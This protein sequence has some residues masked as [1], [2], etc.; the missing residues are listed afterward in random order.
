VISLFKVRVTNSTSAGDCQVCFGSDF[1]EVSVRA[2]L[3]GQSVHKPQDKKSLRRTYLM[4]RI[5]VGMNL[6]AKITLGL[7]LLFALAQIVSAQ[8]PLPLSLDNNYMV[9][10]DY[11]V[12]GWTKT[13]GSIAINGMST[14]TIPI[15]DVAAYASG[16]PLQQVP[17]GADIVAAFLYWQAVENSGVHSGQNGFFG[18]NGHLYPIAGTVLGNPK[19]PVSWSSGGCNGGSGSKTMVT[20]R[21]EVSALLPVDVNGNILPNTTYNVS[22]PD[23]GKAGQ[24]PFTEGATLVIVYR[25]L[26]PN[27]PLNAVVIYDGA[28]APNNTSQI[29]TH[30]LIGFFQAGNDRAPLGQAPIA[31]KIT[32]IVGNGQSNK[33]EQVYL[34]N[35]DST[36]K[37]VHSTSL[38]SLYGA[39]PPFPGNYNGTWDNPTWFPNTYPT[40]PLADSAVMAGESSETTVVVPNGSNKGCVSWGAIVMSTTVQDTDLDGLL[41]VWKTNQGYYD[42]GA[43][44]GM[45]NQGT[46]TLSQSTC[47]PKASDPAWVDLSGA[48]PGK[49]DIFV[50]LDYMCTIVVK[51]AD[52]TTTCDLSGVSYK[53]S[54]DAIND[55]V[56]AFSSPFGSVS[57]FNCSNHT[58]HNIQV[59]VVPDDN[60]VILAQT[61]A[62]TVDANG[63]PLYCPHPGQ[64]G[65]GVVDW[66]LGYFFLKTQPLNAVYPDEN[67]CETLTPV[68]NGVPGTPGTGP[69]C[70]RRFQPGKNNS[71]HEA[72]FAVASA[73]PNWFFQ[74][75]SLTS[76][77]ATANNTLTFTTSNP[78]GLASNAAAPNGRVTISGAISNPSLNGTYVVQTVPTTTSF[79]IQLATA[80]APPTLL[81]DPSFSVASGA[82]G[83]GSGLSDIGGADSLISLGLWGVDGQT[84]PVESGTFM[85][86]LGHSLGLTHGGFFRTPA[87]GAAGGYTFSFEPNCKSNFQSVMNYLFQVDLLDGA[88]DYSDQVLNL[89]DEAAGSS[90]PPNNG[91][92]NPIH[93]TTKWYTPIQPFTGSPATSHCDGTPISA[94]DQPKVQPMF[95]L[96]G[97]VVGP[98]SIAWSANQDI[99]FDGQIEA[100]LQGYSD[101]DSVDLR[102]IGATG[103][104]AWAAGLPALPKAGG[105]PALPKAGGLPA[106]PK[107]GGLPALPKAGGV[108]DFSLKDASSSVRVPT[109]VSATLTP[110][111]TVQVSFTPPG[112]LQS[113]ITGFNVYRSKNGGPFS[114]L[115]PNPTVPVPAG[116][117]LPLTTFMF[118]DTTAACGTFTYFVTT[119]ITDTTGITGTIG[120][121][122]SVPSKTAVPISVPCPFVGFLSPLSTAGTITAPTFSGTVNQGSAV[123]LKWEILEANGM[124]IGDLSTLQLMQACPTTGRLVPP[125]SSTIP[126]CVLLY[127]PTTGAKGNSTFRFS[128]PQFIFNW[129]TKSTIGIVAGYFTVEVTLS[130]GSAVKATTIQFQ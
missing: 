40:T 122:E 64:A 54:Q 47:I 75:G 105:L 104:N 98:N 97:P 61:C 43:N 57:G 28:F 13:P 23:T 16:L 77:V 93:P 37:L 6:G 124:P 130:D 53:P 113:L 3:V 50:Q 1:S 111:N 65:A 52:G 15:P 121:R 11:V 106:L 62:D 19:A 90:S 123:P 81:S 68:V 83:S 49:Q 125:P 42:A 91:L 18:A 20:Y 99:N 33:L 27:V 32:H 89:L 71:Y 29:A 41:D 25:L 48:T 103:N 84:I 129:D 12:G 21:A 10:G 63:N 4:Q 118:T 26:A 87:L 82:V 78:H 76:V 74:N 46:C 114:Q 38:T 51:H 22:L 107:A 34:N 109:A 115:P 17:A 101:W 96:E 108:G 110:A 127:S 126:P 55:V 35:Y 8:T 9:T 58:N 79:T 66:K 72:I 128:N 67:S 85:H 14:G 117:P 44:R 60:N 59:H 36:G 56:C 30:P 31:T 119:V 45:S 100:S 112:F 73:I 2:S 95:R 116:T 5:S 92:G 88:L 102:Q 70:L 7:M 69:V 39:N 80:T 94:N 120:T 86:E 24:P